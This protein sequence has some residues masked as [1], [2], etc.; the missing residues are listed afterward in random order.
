MTKMKTLLHSAPCADDDLEVPVQTAQITDDWMQKKNGPEICDPSTAKVYEEHQT[1]RHVWD[2]KMSSI[3]KFPSKT[4]N[5]F[6]K[7]LTANPD[8]SCEDSPFI[9][10]KI[11]ITQT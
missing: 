8:P 9:E 11:I 4:V 6:P 3:H 5:I 1:C 10:A 7:Q 2:L